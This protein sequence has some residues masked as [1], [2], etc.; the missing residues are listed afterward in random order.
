MQYLEYTVENAVG[1]LTINRPQALNALNSEMVA[2]L[3]TLLKEIAGSN[4][5]CLILTGAGEKAFVAG[6]DIGEMKDFN[7]S[8]AEAFSAEGNLVMELLEGLPMPVIAAVNGFALGGGCELALSCDIRI[9]ADNAV[10]ALPEVG[11]GILPGYGG[12][13]R[14]VRTVGL[15]RAKELAYTTRKVKA[16][17]ALAIG[18]ANQVVPAAS[19]ME[20]ALEMAQ[21]I[22]ANA[23]FGVRAVKQVAD[24][25]VGLPL[26]KATRLE[27]KVFGQCFATQDQKEGMAAFL[28]KRK[29]APYTGK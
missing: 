22:A 27:T 17:E 16:E 20:K 28:E 7:P 26:N 11:L 23:P 19:L 25:S 10:F 24:A 29:P 6:A 9:C 14:L 8:E 21:K 2:E 5:R 15:A 18:L 3:T 12:V 1:T 4:L 13:Q